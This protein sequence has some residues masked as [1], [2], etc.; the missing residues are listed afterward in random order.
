MFFN[1]LKKGFLLFLFFAIFLIF[2]QLIDLLQS[3]FLA[4][5]VGLLIS[6]VNFLTGAAIISWGVTKSD[7]KFY[8]LFFT[9]ML[10]RFVVI[11]LV[12]FILIK[13]FLL[14]QLVL[15]I[16]LLITY[17]GFMAVEIWIINA[18]AQKKGTL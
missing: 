10:L 16:S 4:G 5:W 13:I 11:F 3:G 15:L 6:F 8:S 18:T 17:F 1:F 7:K 14:S 2:L 12:L 9:G